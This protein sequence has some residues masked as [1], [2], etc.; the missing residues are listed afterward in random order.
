MMASDLAHEGEAQ[1]D[2][3]FA[4]A[5]RPIKRLEDP[6]SLELWD[7]RPAVF[8]PQPRAPARSCRH[9]RFHG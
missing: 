1:A 8:D 9:A 2:A 7:A 6:L 5:R 3:A 4:E